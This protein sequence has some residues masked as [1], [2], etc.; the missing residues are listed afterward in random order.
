MAFW[1]GLYMIMVII[2]ESIFARADFTYF[3]GGN[4][5]FSGF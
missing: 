4:K 1:D 3:F 5:D 2:C